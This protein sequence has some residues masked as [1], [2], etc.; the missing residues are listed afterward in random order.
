V[1]SADVAELDKDSTAEAG[2][3]PAATESPDRVVAAAGALASAK[4]APAYP[5]DVEHIWTEVRRLLDDKPRIKA[6]MAKT[7]PRAFDGDELV[8]VTQTPLVAD[9]LAKPATRAPIEDALK[10]VVGRAVRLRCVT[11]NEAPASA[12][13]TSFLPSETFVDKAARHLRDVHME[14]GSSL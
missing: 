10:R 14:R 3:A 6:I 1:A 2:E 7:S 12:G 13:G 11:I 9:Q 4:P 8:L 5:Q